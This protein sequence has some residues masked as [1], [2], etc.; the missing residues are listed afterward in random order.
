MSVAAVA[1]GNS[2]A[3]RKVVA[4]VQKQR[5]AIEGQHHQSSHGFLP[6]ESPCSRFLHPSDLHLVSANVVVRQLQ[7]S[8]P[9]SDSA[10]LGSEGMPRQFVRGSKAEFVESESRDSVQ[11]EPLC[12][13]RLGAL[14]PAALRLEGRP[15]AVLG[16]L[17]LDK[18]ELGSCP[19]RKVDR[20]RQVSLSERGWRALPERLRHA[21]RSRGNLLRGSPQRAQGS[22]A[23]RT[24]GS[25]RSAPSGSV[26]ESGKHS[27][28]TAA[29]GTAALGT[30]A[31]G[32]ARLLAGQAPHS[33]SPV[34]E[35]L[36]DDSVLLAADTVGS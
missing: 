29:L 31:L 25:L 26:L 27:Q 9:S 6:I 4:E 13:V 32:T 35:W 1:T 30:A 24:S 14:L 7:N 36:V 17:E 8:R 33:R 10:W 34:P 5:L 20:C 21:T 2:A 22:F 19:T 18:L 15:F 11:A 28:G 3:D 12:E 23:V 16:K